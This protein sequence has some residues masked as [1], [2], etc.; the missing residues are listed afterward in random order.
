MYKKKNLAQRR[1]AAKTPRTEQEVPERTE[2]K[3]L[4]LPS[5][6]SVSSVISCSF[7]LSASLRL[8]RAF[9]HVALRSTD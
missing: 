3:R 6:F 9:F 2:D 4:F 5:A 1:K 7:L 8:A